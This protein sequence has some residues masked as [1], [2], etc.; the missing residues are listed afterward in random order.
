M[1]PASCATTF[2][3]C[4]RITTCVV[5]SIIGSAQ[6]LIGFCILYCCDRFVVV[7]FQPRN[8]S[9]PMLFGTLFPIKRLFHILPFHFPCVL[10][11]PFDWMCT[12]PRAECPCRNAS[13]F[14]TRAL[15]TRFW[16]ASD[17]EGRW[18][19]NTLYNPISERIVT[20]FALCLKI[21]VATA[22]VIDQ[23]VTT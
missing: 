15:R 21:F 23:I 6:L 22:L 5:W 8:M 19:D 9:G 16:S 14:L 11:A 10:V 12:D 13:L 18:R 4:G 17:G 3:L 7:R 20:Q 2:E 1:S